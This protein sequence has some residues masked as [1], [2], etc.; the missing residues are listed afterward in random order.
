MRNPESTK[1]TTR[2]AAAAMTSATGLLFGATWLL[3]R[4]LVWQLRRE[5][6]NFTSDHIAPE[7]AST[8][9]D[10]CQVMGCGAPVTNVIHGWKVCDEHD[11]MPAASP[12][13]YV[14]PGGVWLNADGT[15]T[16]IADL[17]RHTAS[18]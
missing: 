13:V 4:L 8:P 15:T 7:P 9:V 6:V 5:A 10:G 3:D 1:K 17:P 2:A 12:A 16:P 18:A 14:I 11:P